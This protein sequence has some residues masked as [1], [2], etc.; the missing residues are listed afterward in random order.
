MTLEEALTAYGEVGFERFELFTSWCKSAAEPTAEPDAYLRLARKHGFQFSSIHVPPIGDDIEAGI[1]LAAQTCRL[2]T[3]LGCRAALV[4]AKSREVYI[5][6][7]EKLLN[8]ITDLPIIPVLQNHAGSPISTLDDYRAVLEGIDDPR[9]K[10]TLEVGHF[11]SVGVPWRAGYDLLQGR[12]ELVHIKDQIG[13]QSVP[14]GKGEID[15]RGLFARLRDDGYNG[16]VVIE[17]E[18]EDRGNTRTYLLDALAYVGPLLEGRAAPTRGR[19]RQADH[20]CHS[21]RPLL[22]SGKRTPL[23]RR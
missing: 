17:M 7:A 6:A 23:A 16:D 5:A 18:V 14:F 19:L 1:A 21:F 8:A 20:F 12:I 11:H 10:C 15:L 4:K 9:M 3:A 22:Q 13:P 2:G